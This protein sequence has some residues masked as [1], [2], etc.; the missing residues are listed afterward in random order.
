MDAYGGSTGT[1]EKIL[2]SPYI[3]GVDGDLSDQHPVS[4]STAG[5][6][7]SFAT[8]EAAGLVFYETDGSSKVECGTCHDPHLTDNGKFLRISNVRSAMCQV[9]HNK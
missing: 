9:C 6:G 1:P 2:S 4:I 3:I 5:M 7:E 8:A